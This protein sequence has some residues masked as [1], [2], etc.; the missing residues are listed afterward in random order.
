MKIGTGTKVDSGSRILEQEEPVP[1]FGAEA[2]GPQS[3]KSWVKFAPPHVP[4]PELFGTLTNFAA[5]LGVRNSEFRFSFG[6]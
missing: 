1:I 6:S 2:L 3:S 5:P 4:F